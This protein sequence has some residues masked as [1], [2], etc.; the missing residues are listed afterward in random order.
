[1]SQDTVRDKCTIFPDG[2]HCFTY[3]AD[4]V[5]NSSTFC[6]ICGEQIIEYEDSQP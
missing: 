1:M 6:C 3:S 2:Y 4:G 5:L